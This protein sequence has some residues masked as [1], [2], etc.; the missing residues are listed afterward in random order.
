KSYWSSDVCSSDL[1]TYTAFD[2]IHRLWES[3]KKKKVL[4]LADKNILVDQTMTND[5]KPFEKVMT[6]VENRVLDSSYEIYMALYH[7][8]AGD[9]GYEPFRQFKR[10]FFDLIIID[11]AHRGSAREES[12]WRKIL[13]Y[14]SLV[15][16]RH[17]GLTAT[18]V[19]TKE[20]SSTGYFGE[21]VYTYS[22]KQGI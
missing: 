17:I 5:F 15:N 12:A 3:G 6:K 16:T 18:P 8:L 11:E 20:A 7:Q 10:D 2:I 4:F 19:E 21:P 13:E 9:E 22:L 1:K 14:F